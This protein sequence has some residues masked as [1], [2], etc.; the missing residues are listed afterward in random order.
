MLVDSGYRALSVDL[1]AMGTALWPEDGD[2]S[3][4]AFAEDVV[5]VGRAAP[6][7][8]I[9]IGAPL[10][11]LASLM[12]GARR[13]TRPAWPGPRQA[14]VAH[15]IEE[16]GR[17]RIGEFMSG[18]LDGFATLEEAADAIAAYNPH[19]PCP[20]DLSGLAKNPRRQPDGR[21]VWHWDPASSPGADS[22]DE[23]RASLLGPGPPGSG[24]RQ[25]EDPHP[26]GPGRRRFSEEG[27]QEFLRRLPTPSSSSGG[28]RPHGGRRPQRDLQPRHPRLRRPPPSPDHA[29][30]PGHQE[31]DPL[32]GTAGYYRPTGPYPRRPAG[33]AS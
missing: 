11:G 27:A 14:D 31:R 29:G 4:D 6:S 23:N 13:R 32:E 25:P 20:T 28:G 24:G 33:A 22:A 1:W 10:G 16:G 26:A 18:S 19:R 3:F 15:R 5:A 21:W 8:S 2:Y 30:I 12:A 17:D 7:Y 9:L